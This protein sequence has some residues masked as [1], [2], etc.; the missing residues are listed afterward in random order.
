MRGRCL[1]IAL[2]LVAT[3]AYATR[4]YVSGFEWCDNIDF[5]ADTQFIFSATNGDVQTIA[6]YGVCSGATTV[7]CSSNDDCT[8]NGTCV[9]PDY[10]NGTSGPSRGIYC[11]CNSNT[12]CTTGNCVSSQS[13]YSSLPSRMS[14]SRSRET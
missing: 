11:G 4:A 5:S 3:P 7:G 8:S 1:V 2:L 13:M 6:R 10:C 12:D 14:S 9:R